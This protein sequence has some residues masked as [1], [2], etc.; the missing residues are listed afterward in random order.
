MSELETIVLDSGTGAYDWVGRAALKVRDGITILA[1]YKAK[2]HYTNEGAL[3][4]RFSADYGTTWSDEDKTLTGDA[5]TNFPMNPSTVT[6]GEDAGEPWLYLAPNGDLILHMWRATY[7]VTANGTY[8]SVST[9]GGLTWSVSAPVDF[10]NQDAAAD[11]FTFATQDD[12]VLD[13]VIYAA[14]WRFNNVTYTSPA[15]TFIKSTDNGATWEYVSDIVA[16]GVM[17]TGMEYVGN[18]TIVGLVRSRDNATTLK[19]VSTDMGLTWTSTNI[20]ATFK[21]LGRNRVYTLA[22]LRGEANWWTD[23]TLIC[24]GFELTNPG[25]SQGRKNAVWFSFDS[26]ATWVKQYPLDVIYEDAGYGDMIYD[27]LT[28]K[29]VY[30]TYRGTLEAAELV[31]YKFRIDV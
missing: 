11:L 16:A 17:E 20:T 1:Y 27:P 31:Q 6:P 21:S 29:Y 4:I 2:T 28:Q 7:G 13:G 12:F 19:V 30:I 15:N 24:A 5:V 23:P 8:Q 9:D 14:A 3:H 18:N 22:H 25:S 10:A 26:G